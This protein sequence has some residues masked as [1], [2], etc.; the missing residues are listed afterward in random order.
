MIDIIAVI[1]GFIV[2]LM[3]RHAV[4]SKPE[5][6]ETPRAPLCKDEPKKVN[7]PFLVPQLGV[8][9]DEEMEESEMERGR[10]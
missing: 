3:L 7:R 1:G 8:K 4:K 6:P 5:Q 2:F 10:R 9:V